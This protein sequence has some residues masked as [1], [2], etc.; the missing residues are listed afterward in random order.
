MGSVLKYLCRLDHSVK[1]VVA[2]PSQSA[3]SC[4]IRIHLPCFPALATL[5]MHF[6]CCFDSYSLQGKENPFFIIFLH[7]TSPPLRSVPRHQ[8]P[9][10]EN[11]FAQE[12]GLP[13][14]GWGDWRLRDSPLAL[15]VSLMPC[16][17]LLFLQEQKRVIVTVLL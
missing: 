9:R 4:T 8:Q 13:D 16:S 10:P 7:H 2:P 12:A 14:P 3:D 11:Q 5:L 17:S 6:P 1:R 15:H